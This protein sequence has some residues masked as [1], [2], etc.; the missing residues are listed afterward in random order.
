MKL[1]QMSGMEVVLNMKVFL[2][3]IPC[4]DEQNIDFESPQRENT[5]SQVILESGD[6]K[7][8]A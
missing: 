1:L 5:Q 8:N 3:N 6:L 4:N 7:T 2:Q